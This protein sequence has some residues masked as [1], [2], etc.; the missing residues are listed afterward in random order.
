MRGLFRQ[1]REKTK[2]LI[3]RIGSVFGQH[4]LEIPQSCPKS[5]QVRTAQS[6]NPAELSEVQPRSDSTIQ[7]SRRAVRSPA[8]FGQHNPEIPQSCPKSSQVRTAQSR[9]PAE[10]SEVQPRSD[11]TSQ[12]SRRAV[13]SPAKI[14][15]HK[16][17][18]PQ[19][20]PK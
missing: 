2:G 13:R 19:C 8:K 7:K 4:D 16:P 15:Q 20:C 5:S 12:K 3:V 10:L 6:R 1:G 11:S 9:N 18:I 14:G 17:E